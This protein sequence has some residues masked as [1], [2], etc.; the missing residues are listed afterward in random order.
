MWVIAWWVLLALV[1]VASLTTLSWQ[2][3]AAAAIAAG[4]CVLVA[5][6]A[7]RVL[8]GRCRLRAAW[9]RGL[10]ALPRAVL[11]ETLL[12]WRTAARRT[13]SPGGSREVRLGHERS[14]SR[15]AS[16]VLL[17][18][19]AP[20]TVV[21]DV[22]RRANVVRVHSLAEDAEDEGALERAVRS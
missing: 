17:L 1:W 2:E 8:A 5:D 16:A 21:V 4:L 7:R 12:V 15:Q 19:A 9:L 22:D 13:R 3:L 11:T 14:Q 6:R 10:R 18:G 20:A